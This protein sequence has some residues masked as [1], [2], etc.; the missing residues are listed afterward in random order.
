MRTIIFLSFLLFQFSTLQAQQVKAQV[1]EWGSKKPVP[2]ANV[3][4]GEHKGVV[5]NE[6]GF[7]SFTSEELPATLEISSLGYEA[8]ELKPEEINN[9]IVYLKPASI[10]LKEVFLSNKELSPREI[11]EMAK[12]KVAD[13]YDFDLGQK[14]VFYRESDFS[15]IR[16]FD[17]KVEESTIP[18]IDQNLM[19]RIEAEM[20]KV[21]DSYKEVLADL[22]GNYDSQKVRIVK[23]ANLYNPQNTQSL[24]QLT[25]HLETLFRQNLKERSFLKIRSGLLGVKVDEDELK[26]GFEDSDTD[27]KEKTPE[28]IAEKEAKIKKNLQEGTGKEIQSLLANMFWKEDIAFNLFEKIRKYE[29]DLQGILHLG[30]NTVYVINFEPKR[31]ADF[32]GKIFIDAHDYGVHRI[33]YENVRPLS[34]FRLFG[35][36]AIDDIYRGKMFF[37]KDENGKYSLSYLERELGETVG[38]DRPL[39]IIEKNRHV[40][41][42]NKQNEL[43][44]ELDMRFGQVEKCSWWSMRTGRLPV[45]NMKL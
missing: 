35:I 39:T 28:E 16:K 25:E 22:Y 2:Y 30:Q 10:E 13:N 29:F 27:K 24:D 33:E 34:K 45:K 44:L 11:V 40:P 21:T 31:R 36:S 5:T 32:K 1:L 19:D 15:H 38:I 4:F 42:R 7:F 12:E 18:G 43:D 3:I 6:E 8:V 17:M 26:E 41:G 9:S 37:M 23:A 14:R 20:P